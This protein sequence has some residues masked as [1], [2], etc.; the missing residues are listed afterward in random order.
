MKKDILTPVWVLGVGL[1]SLPRKTQLSR[2][3]SNGEAMPRKG[4][5][6]THKITIK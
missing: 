1:A 5:E 6:A 2:N 3:S 4:A